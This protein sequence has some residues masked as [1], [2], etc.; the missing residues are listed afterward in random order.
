MDENLLSNASRH[1]MLEALAHANVATELD[2]LL[3]SVDEESVL[4]PELLEFLLQRAGLDGVWLGHRGTDGALVFDAVAGSGLA[5]YL[6]SVLIPLDGT[7][8]HA[9]PSALAWQTGMPQIVTD[10]A[11]DPRTSTWLEAG[12]LAGWQG[13][14][15]LPVQGSDGR[16]DLLALYSRQV[17]FFEQIHNQRLVWHLHA[18]LGLKLGRIR[19]M[20]QL[21]TQGQSLQLLKAAIEAS[22]AGMCVADACAPDFPLVYVN[23]AFERM[24]GYTEVQSLGRNCRF[25][26]G[27]EHD[28]AGLAEVRAALHE[29][30]SCNVELRNFRADGSSFWNGLNLTPVRNEAGA[31]THVVA[32]MNDVSARHALEAEHERAQGLYRALL[33]EEELVLSA[34]DIAEML[35]QA[36]ERLTTSGLF[37]A[38][39]IGR[40]G[41]QGDIDL[42]AQAGSAHISDAWYRP[43][44]NDETADQSLAARVWNSK[45]LQFSND[46]LNEPAYARYRDKVREAGVR[47]VAIAPILRGGHRWA[48]LGVVSGQV[49]VFTPQV[50]ELLER[51]ARLIGHGL[52]AFD[53]RRRL[54]QEHRHISWLAEHDPLTGL[55]NRRGLRL[56]LE[57]ALSQVDVQGGFV[58]IGILDFDDFK[59]INDNYGHAAGD[60]LLRIV[61]AR[62]VE[63]V[64][65][66]DTVARLGGDEI[67]LVLQGLATRDDIDPMLKRIRRAV[68]LPVTLPGGDR[69]VHV[70]ASLGFT[71]YPDDGAEPDELLRHAD[72]ALYAIKQQPRGTGAPFWRVYQPAVDRDHFNHLRLVRDR[73]AAGGLRV[74]YQPVV[75][76]ASGRVVEVEALARLD[77]GE[78]KLI[79]PLDFIHQLGREGLIALT[80]D[81][82]RQAVADARQWE[83]ELGVELSVAVNLDPVMLATG[84]ALAVVK[85][86]VAKQAF[87]AKRI[88][89]EILEHSDFLSF[90]SA[91]EALSEL[92]AVGCRIALDDIGSAYS[93]LLRMKE[94][95]ID[96]IKLDQSFIRG[97]ADRPQDLRFVQSLTQL[98]RGLGVDFVAEGA[99]TEDI[100]EAL[101]ALRVPQAQGYGIARPMPAAEFGAWLLAWSQHPLPTEPGLLPRIAEMLV[102]LDTD[103]L[104]AAR[105]PELIPGLSI[106]QPKEECPI[107]QWLMQ[108]GLPMDSPII[109]AHLE[110]HAMFNDW[111]EAGPGAD[112]GMIQ[113]ALDHFLRTAGDQLRL[114]K[115]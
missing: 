12:R 102:T 1:A 39:L 101:R 88:V 44:I 89:L 37:T 90:A 11:T 73:F 43:N 63:A 97:L 79:P 106:S 94:L 109:A 93:S 27:E 40:A 62:L 24:T 46:Y 57:E 50:L 83:R 52:D 85:D 48:M 51:V 87:P 7:D 41:P 75:D 38:A 45:Q 104:L 67:A 9:G 36:C 69:I 14:A 49:G 112:S 34:T 16:R 20:R 84:E 10:W 77:D 55:L 105:N 19:L 47:S 42:F 58:A 78:G 66:S 91:Q 18:V 98:A 30:R 2:L 86:V 31:I 23:P 81:V 54:Q 100:V 8:L 74:H 26:Q 35:Q 17:G 96:I 99:E 21:S 22:E 92:R 110:L 111:L 70:R 115:A 56:R 68:D 82:L 72:Q 64:R 95:P 76:L 113:S 65:S 15:T 25:L 60:S 33:E 61:A 103:L 108:S 29:G 107:C 4:Y 28:Q 59:Q 32:I 13:S 6:D 80:G 53:L 5:A 114:A 71:L 3:L